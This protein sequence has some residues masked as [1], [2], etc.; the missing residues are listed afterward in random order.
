MPVYLPIQRVWV[1]GETCAG[2]RTVFCESES[3]LPTSICSRLAGLPRRV[4]EKTE[5]NG[6]AEMSER[7]RANG[8][9][10]RR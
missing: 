7:W 10:G 8:R 5:A 3:S 6:E 2:I 9:R 4:Y 1:V